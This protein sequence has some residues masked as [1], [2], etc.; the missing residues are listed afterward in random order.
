MALLIQEA[1]DAGR[2]DRTKLKKELA[3]KLKT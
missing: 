2:L 1:V 3:A